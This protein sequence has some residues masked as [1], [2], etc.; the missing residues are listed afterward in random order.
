MWNGTIGIFTASPA[1]SAKNNQAIIVRRVATAVRTSSS[2]FCRSATT[3]FP[4]TFTRSL[5][6]FSDSSC[7]V[8]HMYAFLMSCGIENVIGPGFGIRC[9][10]SGFI[11]FVASCVG[12][13]YIGLPLSGFN[14]IGFANT[15]PIMPTSVNRLPNKV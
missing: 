8:S 4:A 13:L 14:G 15:T 1:M 9:G 11:G 3:F 2:S 12:A 7:A 10:P 6:D 5:A